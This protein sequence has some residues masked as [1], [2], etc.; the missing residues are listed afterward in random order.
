VERVSSAVRLE[1]RPGEWVP[2]KARPFRFVSLNGSTA[3]IRDSINAELHEVAVTDLRG[4]QVYRAR[5]AKSGYT[6]VQY[7]GRVRCGGIAVSGDRAQANA[8]VVNSAEGGTQ[9][10]VSR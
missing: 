9:D 10:V 5:P 1:L 6:N 3:S 4:M 7:L 2:W 8:R